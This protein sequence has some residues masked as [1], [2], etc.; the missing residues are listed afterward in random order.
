M[1]SLETGA[2]L[3]AANHSRVTC[4]SERSPECHK[5]LSCIMIAFLVLSLRQGAFFFFYNKILTYFSVAFLLSTHMTNFKK[6][7]VLP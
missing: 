5:P 2:S 6:G 3:Q 7:S 1:Q 4:T